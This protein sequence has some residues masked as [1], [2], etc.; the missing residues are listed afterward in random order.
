MDTGFTRSVA[1]VGLAGMLMLAGCTAGSPDPEPSLPDDGAPGTFECLEV[2]PSVLEAIASGAGDLA[3]TPTEQSAA[4]A[5]PSIPDAYLVAAEYDV[6]GFNYEV[7]VWMVPT[8]DGEP[9]E[10]AAV[11]EV[12]QQFTAYPTTFGG[13]TV[14]LTDGAVDAVIGCIG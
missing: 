7:G 11:D 14:S 2:S 9:S 4:V 1:V 13:Q 5:S 10:I 8:L 3:L 12:S 6:A